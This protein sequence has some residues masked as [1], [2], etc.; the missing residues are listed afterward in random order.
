MLRNVFLVYVIINFFRQ[1]FLVAVY[2]QVLGMD[3]YIKPRD[4][5]DHYMSTGMFSISVIELWTTS[6][7]KP[8]LLSW[9]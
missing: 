9:D 1:L 2:V 4:S 8:V 3:I 5:N 7:P 6:G